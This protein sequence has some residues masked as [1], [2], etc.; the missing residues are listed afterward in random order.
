MFPDLHT[1]RSNFFKAPHLTRYWSGTLIPE[2]PC[3]QTPQAPLFNWQRRCTGEAYS[4]LNTPTQIFP[5]L[6]T[7][8]RT[9][10]YPTES[11]I[12]KVHRYFFYQESPCWLNV[13]NSCRPTNKYPD[14]H[15]PI[16]AIPLSGVTTPKKISSMFW[17]STTTTMELTLP[18]STNGNKLK[19]LPPFWA[20]NTSV[21]L[22]N[23]S[24][25]S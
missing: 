3:L 9:L 14:G 4:P 13:D 6:S 11:I 10:L 12:F 8:W 20:S 7:F 15:P 25:S 23:S 5:W 16:E 22:L 19:S 1:E 17:L 24:F 2:P 18:P 21:T